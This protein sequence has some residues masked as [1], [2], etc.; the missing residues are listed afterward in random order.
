MA[1]SQGRKFKVALRLA[2]RELR[3][4]WKH[5][6]VFVACLTLG[7]AIMGSVKSFGNMVE[8]A[9]EG[10]AKSL[11]GGDIEAR[12]SGLEATP[13]QR[14]FLEEYGEVSYVT[15]LRS[16]LNSGDDTTLVEIKA[17][18]DVYPLA[19]ELL[20]NEA[21][22]RETALMDNGVIVDTI[23][24]S[25][26][27]LKIGDKVRLGEASYAIRATLKKEP[28]RVVQ[29]FNFGPRV[30]LSHE[31]L[32]Q[33]GL[34]KTF[35]LIE[36]RYRILTPS[37]VLVDEA[38]EKRMEDQLKQ[39]FPNMSWR[40]RTGTDGNRTVERFTE[41]L[42][43]FL[44]LSALATFLIAGI[45]IGSSARA[46]LEKKLQTI[47][48][49]KVLGASRRTVLHT[50]LIVLGTLA[51]VGGLA[52]IAI[53]LAILYAVLPLVAPL[54]PALDPQAGVSPLPFLLAS[55]Y[56]FLIAYLFSM[57]ALLNALDVR[58]SLLFRSKTGILNFRM[59][60]TIRVVTCALVT[61]LLVTLILTAQDVTFLLGAIGV[62]SLA[63]V[64]FGLCAIVVRRI[65]RGIT[66][67]RPWLKLA[68]GN[69]HRPGSTTGTVIFAI[70]ISL[71]VLIALTLTEANFQA[72]I[73][74]LAKE[75]APSL[76]MMDIQPHHKD[77]LHTLLHEYAPAENVMLYP[78]VRGRIS[79]INGAP[80]KESDVD[81]DIR[82]AIRGD[83]G[84]SASTTIPENAKLIGGQWWPED[85]S[86][87]PL[88]SVDKR[89]IDGMDLDIGSTLMLNI[90]GEDIIAEVA[91]ARDIDYTTFQIN[92][93][94]MLSPGVVDTFPRTYLA[95]IHLDGPLEEEAEL[96]RKIA[97]NL[98]GI[99][100]IRTT[101]VVEIVRD[102]IRHIATALHIAVSVSLFAG[103]LVLTSALTATIEQRLYDTAVLKVLGARQRDILKSCTAEWMLLALITS[104]IAAGIGTFGS[105]LVN[106]RFRNEDF[107]VMPEVTLATIAACI[108]V[109]WTTGYIGNRR[110]FRLRPAGLLR[111]E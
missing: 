56:G 2:A 76:F 85:Y 38:F 97:N 104:V 101:E 48:V 65:A 16:M 73:E 11:L 21:I 25:Q 69:L 54:L 26:L 99:T 106:N 39:R 94:L 22:T 66:V 23:L 105:W 82:W 100:I 77:A 4:G 8:E 90:L 32:R 91:S 79:E 18:D 27:G 87:P 6:F 36:H 75:D 13:E 74:R 50:Y 3:H 28:D 5:F 58:P 42:I 95:T 9:L 67:R 35:S 70:G 57:P 24:L 19:G 84:I 1:G 60:G 41:Q 86:G 98:P 68:L 7:V 17:I 64:L 89:F 53:S 52:G 55:W 61:L 49:F 107:A 51:L 30:M 37:G 10:E 45:G 44:T 47:A 20:F 63:F 29:I 59:S 15:T 96:V 109:I 102:I 81:A 110:L 83:R 34:I 103:L 14:A 62:M 43:S 40:V 92:F 78:M 33:S 88:L 111:N 80:V 72:R 108:I 93:A 12:L 46:Y 71:T 31:A